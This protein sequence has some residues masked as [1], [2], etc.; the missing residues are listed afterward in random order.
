MLPIERRERIEEL[1]K[2]RKNLKISDLKEILGVSEMTIH[3]DTKPMIEEGLIMKSFGGITLV[4]ETPGQ[5]TDRD[6]C[7]LCN[8]KVK[9]RLSYRLIL[10][11]NT[12]EETCCP[13]CGLIRHNQ[14]GDEVLEGLCNDFLFETT[15]SARVTWFVFDSTINIGCCIP[16]ILSFENKGNAEK[17][18]KGFGGTIHNFNEAMEKVTQS[19]KGFNSTSCCHTKN[20]EDRN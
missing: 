11:N 14:L 3:R 5:I 9:Q 6:D 4:R 17:F 20:E 18:I 8:R 19:I 7:V 13:H 2:E 1:I 10:K 12:I 16:Q 15:V